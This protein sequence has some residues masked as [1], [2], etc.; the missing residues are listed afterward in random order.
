MLGAQIR[1]LRIDERDPQSS[2][3]HGPMAYWQTGTQTFTW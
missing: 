1:G 2:I 3:L